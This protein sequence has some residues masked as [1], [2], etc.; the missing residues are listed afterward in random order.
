M[1]T[2]RNEKGTV[3]YHNK[4]VSL[5]VIVSM[6]GLL[7]MYATHCTWVTSIAY[8]SPSVVLQARRGSNP[9]IFDD[10]REAYQWLYHNTDDNDKVLSWWDYGYQMTGMGNK[11]RNNT[12]IA[13]VGLTLASTE[14]KAYPIL[15]RLDV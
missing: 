8:S 15:K 13:T 12:H 11:T 3:S 14:E 2:S 4:L 10:F 6:S 5:I 7:F 1:L 9:V